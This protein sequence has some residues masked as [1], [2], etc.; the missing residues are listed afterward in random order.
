MYTTFSVPVQIE[1]KKYDFEN[2]ST[3]RIASIFQFQRP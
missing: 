2:V 3:I 1:R